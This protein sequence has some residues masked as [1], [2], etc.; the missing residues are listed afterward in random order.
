MTEPLEKEGLLSSAWAVYLVIPE[1]GVRERFEWRRSSDLEVHRLQGRSKGMSFV[2]VGTGEVMVVYAGV[3]GRSTKKAGKFR[4]VGGRG[5]GTDIG[6][7]GELLCV[8]S[9]LALLE[10]ARRSSNRSSAGGMSGGAIGGS[11]GGFSGGVVC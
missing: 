9:L 4:W 5:G 11:A 10:K 2:R 6:D 7:A 3:S 1:S 8:M